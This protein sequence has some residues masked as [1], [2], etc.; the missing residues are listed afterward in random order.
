M[1]S[2]M[3]GAERYD[4]E[5]ELERPWGH[6]V[7][8]LLTGIAATAFIG[9]ILCS[10]LPVD[11]ADHAGAALL[12]ALVVAAIVWAVAWFVD[13]RR[14]T[15]GW[16]IGAPAAYGMTALVVVALAIAVAN[17]ATRLD[18]AMI[19]KIRINDK[20][21]PELPPGTRPGPMTRM[22]MTYLSDTLKERH[23]RQALLIAG[24]GM[25][26]LTNAA[27]LTSAPQLLTDC[28]RFARA[29]PEID[30]SDKRITSLAEKYRRDVS[31]AIREPS[32]RRQ[33]IDNFDKGFGS[34]ADR[35]R[36]VNGMLKTELDLAGPLCT[37]LARRN[38]RDQGSMFMF[39]NPGDM[40][41]FDRLITPWNDMVRKLQAFDTQS[42]ERMRST[43]MVDERSKL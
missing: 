40:R 42:N 14:T 12:V 8:A 26:R 43:G 17:V 10:T 3:D 31:A 37:L 18:L 21:E 22:S 38:W 28:G 24:L 36:E 23:K 35:L 9:I 2:T 41:E 15:I 39:T 13:L 33:A 34:G 20:G 5:D 11:V 25:D 6:P 4:W 27:A 7:I 1:V 29:K 19:D 30:A 32:L 16:G